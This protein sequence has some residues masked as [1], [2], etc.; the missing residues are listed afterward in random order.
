[1]RGAAAA[2]ARLR[3]GTSG[4]AL[5]VDV[6][7]RSG[8]VDASVVAGVLDPCVARDAVAPELVA[9]SGDAEGDDETR[10][11]DAG[12][13]CGPGRTLAIG[14][15][16]VS[17]LRPTLAQWPRAQADTSAM[18]TEG[19]RDEG[20]AVNV[21]ASSGAMVLIPP[22]APVDFFGPSLALT[23]GISYRFGNLLPGRKGRAAMEVNIGI[24]DGFHFASTGRAGGNAHVTLFHQELRW[25]VLWEILTTY[26]LPLDLARVHRAGYLLFFNGAR[27]HEIISDGPPRFV[28]VEIEAC[29]IALSRGYGTHPLYAISPELR[30]YVGLADPSAAQPSFPSTIGPTFGV[31]ITGGYATFL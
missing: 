22:S 1:V 7:Q 8:A 25:P 27:V 5:A 14:T 4:D 19:H 30:F 28:G 11:D 13:A 21:F 10:S 29:S 18:T 16:G 20:W 15:V 24:S 31:S 12:G 2:T 26:T 9:F 17:L 23:A 3:D 6:K